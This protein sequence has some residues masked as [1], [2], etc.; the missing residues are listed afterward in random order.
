MTLPLSNNAEGGSNGTTVTTGNSGGSS[1]DAF[2]AVTIGAGCTLKF[3]NAQAEGS[4]AYEI[5]TAATSDSSFLAYSTAMGTQTGLFVR[6]YLYLLATPAGQPIHLVKFRDGSTEKGAVRITTGGVLGLRD[7]GGDI[8]GL[9][10]TVIPLN[11]WVR[12]E[13]KIVCDV[14]VGVIECKLFSNADGLVATETLT[15][16]NRNTGTQITNVRFGETSVAGAIT[17]RTFYVDDLE[18]N[19]S[20]YPGPARTT[21]TLGGLGTTTPRAVAAVPAP[22]V[23]ADATASPSP[24][25]AVADAPMPTAEEGI[26]AEPA[27]VAAVAAVPDP[28]ALAV[29]LATPATAAAVAAVPAPTIIS[30]AGTIAGAIT[31]AARAGI[32]TPGVLATRGRVQI[33][34]G[35]E[36][37]GEFPWGGS[38]GDG[39]GPGAI[40]PGHILVPEADDELFVK[41]TA[42]DGR[43]VLPEFVDAMEIDEFASG[44]FIN[45]T[46]QISREEFMDLRDVYVDGAVVE[47]F[48]ASGIQKF[49]GTLLPPSVTGNDADGGVATLKADGV[50]RDSEQMA[51]RLCYATADPGLWVPRNSSGYGASGNGYYVQGEEDFS[52]DQQARLQWTIAKGSAMS[53]GD[54]QGFMVFVPNLEHGEGWR[55]LSFHVHVVPSGPSYELRISTANGPD[56]AFT[57]RDTEALPSGGSHDSNITVD[58]PGIGDLLNIELMRN[59]SDSSTG[60]TVQV[61]LTQIL[62]GLLAGS[63]LMTVDQVAADLAGRLGWDPSLIVPHGLNALPFDQQQGSYADALDLMAMLVDWRWLG[64]AIPGVGPVMDFGPW[65]RRVW[66]ATDP[67]WQSEFTPLR[68]YDS[69]VVP[70]RKADGT[71]SEVIGYAPYKLPKSRRFSDVALGDPLPA[72]EPAQSLADTLAAYFV[73]ERHAGQMDLTQVTDRA[74]GRWP[75]SVLRAGDTVITE[76]GPLRAAQVSTLQSRD[77]RRTTVSFDARYALLD[78]L[79]ARRNQ[80]LRAAGLT[81]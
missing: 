42:P 58:L 33:G 6:I 26:V 29:T 28:S 77:Q 55:F 53:D 73:Q 60:A 41:V 70:C 79:V 7:N 24:A 22:S 61:T 72:E 43:I 3:S 2:D 59:G 23:V 69:T 40:Q 14:S 31:A 45:L 52:L 78:R 74:G 71:P 80:R 35:L 47:V 67:E 15:K 27:T 50:G 19:A 48:A 37:W 64:L 16:S 75:A 62:A 46:G 76:V 25:A 49:Y 32:A 30:G 57:L 68:R 4:L 18:A 11:Q 13:A 12:I 8:G 10:S 9:M 44:G 63:T 81:G 39:T 21:V 5:V 38:S 36:P 65:D 17:A 56:G 1:G 66:V 54:I 20:A 51:G 34:W